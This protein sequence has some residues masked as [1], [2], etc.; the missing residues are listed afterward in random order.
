MLPKKKKNLNNDLLT[1]TFRGK[2][3]EVNFDESR[4][5][6]LK[7]NRPEIFFPYYLRKIDFSSLKIK[8]SELTPSPPLHLFFH[9]KVLWKNLRL[10]S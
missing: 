7:E 2:K 6:N 5:R 9:Q 8:I 3:K 10:V 1:L 4:T